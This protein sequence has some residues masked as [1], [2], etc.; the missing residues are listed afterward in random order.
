MHFRNLVLGTLLCTATNALPW[1]NEDDNQ[2]GKKYEYVAV[3]SV[4]G[5]HSSDVAK[6][7]SLRPKSN[8]S[9]LLATGYEYTNAF[10][11]APSDSFPGTMN[12]F[13]GASPKTTGI[14]YDDIWDRSVY[15]PYSVNKTR[16]EG[17][18]GA[19]GMFLCLIT[20]HVT[21]VKADFSTQ[22]PWQKISTLT[23]PSFSLA[24]SIL[25]NFHRS[26][27]TANAN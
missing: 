13:T 21:A 23:L 17:K 15:P 9:G 10:T 27:S 14:W 2:D 6:Y 16:C 22:S 5:F 8:I 26:P 24:V 20:P 3:F 11:A 12:L 19:E 18:P 1:N 7:T 25:T 4:D